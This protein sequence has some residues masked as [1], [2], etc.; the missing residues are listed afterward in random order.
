M[1]EAAPTTLFLDG[2]AYD[3]QAPGASWARIGAIVP[4]DRRLDRVPGPP[5]DAVEPAR[6]FTID[7]EHAYREGGWGG[8]EWKREG[9]NALS[10]SDKALGDVLVAQTRRASGKHHAL[11]DLG[12]AQPRGAATADGDALP[13]SRAPGSWQTRENCVRREPA[14]GRGACG[15]KQLRCTRSLLCLAC[16]DARWTCVCTVTAP[17]ARTG[18][19]GGSRLRSLRCMGLHA[20]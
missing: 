19:T 5:P 17:Q 18:C 9:S 12:G 14:R 3:T 11:P 16:F 7:G 2:V 20:P 4:Q 8:G 6:G 15:G 10:L 13:V 1:A